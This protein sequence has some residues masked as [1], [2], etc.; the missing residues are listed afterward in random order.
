MN[1]WGNNPKLQIKKIQH[2][3]PQIK[4]K[5]KPQI[6][7]KI[8]IIVSV[9]LLITL[10]IIFLRKTGTLNQITHLYEAPATQIA[11][12]ESYCQ[13]LGYQPLIDKCWLNLAIRANNEKFCS[14]ASGYKQMCLSILEKD[15]SSCDNV[16]PEIKNDCYYS[17]A[18]VRNDMGLCEKGISKSILQFPNPQVLFP[19][20]PV[21]CKID[22]AVKTGSLKSCDKL[23]TTSKNLCIKEL[24]YEYHDQNY[25]ELL[26]NSDRNYCI[27]EISA[28]KASLSSDTSQCKAISNIVFRKKC[29]EY[30]A[31]NTQ[32]HEMCLQ[33]DLPSACILNTIQQILN[34]KACEDSNL[35]LMQKQECLF[36]IAITT[37]DTLLCNE[38]S[39][40]EDCLFQIA[41][42]YSDENV[43][44]ALSDKNNCY[45]E[46]A[47]LKE[48][49]SFCSKISD[50]NL[51]DN[52][53]K[54]IDGGVALLLPD[55]CSIAGFKCK[56]WEIAENTIN[57]E[58]GL[59]SQDNVEEMTLTLFSQCTPTSTTITGD[60]TTTF[61]CDLP[62]DSGT[63]KQDIT[64]SYTENEESKNTIGYVK[65]SK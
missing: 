59:L 7:W 50:T 1:E 33:S 14:K 60:E 62:A 61:K 18:F 35:G 6:P 15:K 32:N 63:Q 26:S 43:C 24:A 10:G 38:L 17:L 23:P 12:T 34:Q 5:S 28:R 40:S 36:T 42:Q 64:I 19:N 55:A 44:E 29:F 48:D 13:K 3:E 41:M 31:V 51:A 37:K 2:S 16:D 25:C 58:V 9:I 52:C 47:K 53:K 39:K 11:Q 4:L 8:L 54:V 27:N 49:S 56:N 22:V 57:L 21:E 46:L 30:L 65:F 45:Y 20:S